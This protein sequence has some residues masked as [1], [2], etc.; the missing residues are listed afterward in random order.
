[1]L[2]VVE[3]QLTSTNYMFHHQEPPL[4]KECIW[5]CKAKLPDDLIKNERYEARIR[6]KPSEYS[7]IWSDWSPTVSW[8]TTTGRAKPPPGTVV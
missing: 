8:V 4:S 3:E 6:V 5:D 2:L 1:M 7:S